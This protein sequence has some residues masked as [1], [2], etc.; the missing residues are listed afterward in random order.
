[1]YNVLT[2]QV[3]TFISLT[4]FHCLGRFYSVGVFRNHTLGFLTVRFLSM[5]DCRPVDQL[6]TWR[7]RPPYL[8][9]SGQGDPPICTSRH[10]LLILFALYD[11]HGLQRSCSLLRS[12][13][14]VKQ[15]YYAAYKI[16]IQNQRKGLSGRHT[17]ISEL[18]INVLILEITM[19]IMCTTTLPLGSY[20]AYAMCVNFH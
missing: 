11:L 12:S 18:V 19:V 20:F 3:A 1:M 13:H 17:S 7:A 14:G 6:A 8:Q 15:I 16:L 4:L 5:K 2:C 10:L 9:P